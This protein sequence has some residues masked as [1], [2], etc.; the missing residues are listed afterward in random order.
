MPLYPMNAYVE[1]PTSIRVRNVPKKIGSWNITSVA[2]TVAYPD[3]SIVTAPC[4]LVGGVWVGTVEGSAQSGKSTKG[5]TIFASGTDENGNAVSDYVL[6]KGDVIIL[7]SDGTIT[8]G[9]DAHYVHLLSSES[10]TPKDGDLFPNSDGTYSIW[11]NGQAHNLAG[12]TSA[13]LDDTLTLYGKA[14]DAKATGDAVSYVNGRVNLLNERVESFDSGL[15]YAVN[16]CTNINTK[17]PEQTWNPGNELADKAFVNSSVQTATANFRGNWNTWEAVPAEGFSDLYP[18]DYAGSHIPT[19]NDYLVVQDASDYLPDPQTHLVG[20]WRFKYSGVW[21][22]VGKSG[23]QPEYQVN[24]TPMTAAQLAALNSG[25]TQALVA[26]FNDTTTKI[27]NTLSTQYIDGDGDIYE[28]SA[29]TTE[30]WT[31]SSVSCQLQRLKIGHFH[32]CLKVV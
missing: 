15:Q 18:A 9:V 30:D 19:V 32:L 11:Q 31:L 5:Y 13:D 6:G 23:W 26:K 29:S 3:G 22:N 10:A 20:T 25:I 1:S 28:L 8:P 17:I 4:K 27:Y 21:S 2:F 7:E 16:T 24:E 12:M 14:A